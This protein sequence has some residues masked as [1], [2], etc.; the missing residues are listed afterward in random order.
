MSSDEGSKLASMQYFDP[1]N[2]RSGVWKQF[3]VSITDPNLAICKLCD[4]RVCRKD[5]NTQGM[6]QHLDRKH[7]I[8][9]SPKPRG[10]TINICFI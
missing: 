7:N 1:T 10:K 4:A 2:K 5:G 8:N 6:R 3:G 9:I